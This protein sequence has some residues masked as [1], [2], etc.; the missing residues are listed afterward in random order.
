MIEKGRFQPT[1]RIR[2]VDFADPYPIRTIKTITVEEFP[3]VSANGSSGS[4]SRSA[5]SPS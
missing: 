5:S 1:G 4:R 3:A 2:V